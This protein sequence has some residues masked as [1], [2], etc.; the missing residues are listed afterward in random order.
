MP[1][2]LD[3]VVGWAMPILQLPRYRGSIANLLTA[4]FST[5]VESNPP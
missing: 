4:P 1:T 2:L 3:I 5:E